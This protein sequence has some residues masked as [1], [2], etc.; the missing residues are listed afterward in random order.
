MLFLF[1]LSEGT[2]EIIKQ[3][4]R[5]YSQARGRIIIPKDTWNVEMVEAM[6]FVS[7][8]YTRVK[9]KVFYEINLFSRYEDKLFL[10]NSRPAYF[11]DD[12]IRA[13]QGAVAINLLKDGPKMESLIP[14]SRVVSCYLL[15]YTQ[16]NNVVYFSVK[17]L[18]N[19]S[20]SP[21]EIIV[22]HLT[23][24]T[25]KWSMSRMKRS[26]CTT[27]YVAYLIL[28]TMEPAFTSATRNGWNFTGRR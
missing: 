24:W 5:E 7:T 25:T 22:V 18:C 19:L 15:H 26:F 11:E 8:R 6:N 3:M 27:I 1:Q 4:E 10:V 9:S 16:A 28:S 17:M 20:I 14:G 23:T 2:K 13:S 12:W 21:H